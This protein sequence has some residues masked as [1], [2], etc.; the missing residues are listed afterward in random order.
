MSIVKNRQESKKL[1]F[2][3]IAYKK[4]GSPRSRRD[5][6]SAIWSIGRQNFHTEPT[7]LVSEQV[8]ELPDRAE[9]ISRTEGVRVRFGRYFRP[10]FDGIR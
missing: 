4:G 8:E 3:V 7:V 10:R 9:L 1:H 2:S 6:S 5:F